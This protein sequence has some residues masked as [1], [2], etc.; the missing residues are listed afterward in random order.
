MS[1]DVGL[2]PTAQKYFVLALHAAKEA[3]DRPLGAYVLSDMSR[4]MIHLGRPDDALELIH[5]A[6]YGSRDTATA[7]TQSMLLRDGGPRLR[8]PGQRAEVPPR[9]PDGRGHLHRLPGRDED[10]DW[11]RFFSEARAQR[12]ERPLLPG[13]RLRRRP[14]PHVRLAGPPGDGS[15]P[16]NCSPGT[17]ST[18]A[19]TP[20][21][22][23]AWPASTC[24]RASPEQASQFA[25]Q[26]IDV[27]RKVRSERVNTRIR[28]TA[29]TALH[30][31]GG[32]AE[33]VALRDRLRADLPDDSGAG[34][35][36]AV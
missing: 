12:G 21:T 11:I 23:S 14:Q 5:L 9:G 34:E 4:Q 32:V 2:Q 27:A 31:Y 1:Y 13:P 29:D 25:E 26:A 22:W 19:P 35:R 33:V 36:T 17:P 28:S 18:S 6:Q 7:T 16:S 20:S 24:W 15:G 3:G 8:Q 10:P 30:D